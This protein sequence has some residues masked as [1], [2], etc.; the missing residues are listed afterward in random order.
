MAWRPWRIALAEMGRDVADNAS[1]VQ[2]GRITEARRRRGPADDQPS[3][4]GVQLD[5]VAA[6]M[7]H[8]AEYTF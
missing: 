6:E 8:G 1:V 3:K 5:W 4:L 7:C 2:S